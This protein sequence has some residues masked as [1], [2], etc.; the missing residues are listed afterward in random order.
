MSGDPGA[1][2]WGRGD[3]EVYNLMRTRISVSIYS[4]NID[5]IC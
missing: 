2:V 4:L 3:K 5:R 1:T